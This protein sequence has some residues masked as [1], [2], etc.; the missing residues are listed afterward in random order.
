MSEKLG[1]LADVYQLKNLRP[2]LPYVQA[3][4]TS[5]PEPRSEQVSRVVQVHLTV[6]RFRPQLPSLRPAP[7][8]NLLAGKCTRHFSIFVITARFQENNLQLSIR[9]VSGPSYLSFINKAS[10]QTMDQPDP[11]PEDRR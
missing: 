2:R 6:Q 7:N 11:I 5:F 4:S 3:S 1:D 10:S 8:R 9:L